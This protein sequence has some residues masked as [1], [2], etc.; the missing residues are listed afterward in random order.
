MQ[1]FPNAELGKEIM[2]LLNSIDEH[3]DGYRRHIDFPVVEQ[4]AKVAAIMQSTYGKE[5]NEN[6]SAREELEKREA[7]TPEQLEWYLLR[8]DLEEI[9]ETYANAFSSETPIP[10]MQRVKKYL[11]E[12]PE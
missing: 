11:K 10:S 3:K 2:A 7:M 8:K 12:H 6:R 1:T 5:T 9:V 4:A